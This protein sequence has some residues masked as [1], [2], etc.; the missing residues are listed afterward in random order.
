MRQ[1]FSVTG[2]T[3]T[4]CSSH[5]EKAVS[6]LNGVLSVNVNLLQNSMTVE[7]DENIL[8][9]GDIAN[10][11]KA[12]GYSA[13]AD[14][15]KNSGSTGSVPGNGEI[16][17]LSRQ[18]TWSLIFLIPLF[19]I[20]MGH[21]M[22]APLPAF[23]VGENN[24]L[25]FA[26]VQFCLTLPILYF[27]RNYFSDGFSALF[28]RSPNMNSLVA[29]GS[30]AAVIYSIYSLFAAAYAAGQNDIH[31]VHNHV[32]NLYFESAGMILTLITLGKF[33]ESR[34]KKSTTEAI[35]RLMNLA[36]KTA[37]VI[38]NGREF[39]I[40]AEDLITGD[41]VVIKPGASIP[42]DG[43]VTEGSSSID[44]SA[45]T[46]ESIPVEKEP[47]SHLFA[48]TINNTG[49]F[50]MKV[51]QVGKDTTLS[52]IIALVEEA[53]N[54]K[55]PIS[56]LADK[57]SGI[58]VPVV[59]TIALL[60]AVIWY[61]IG[62]PFTFILRTAISV[63]VISCPCALG[64]A[65]PTAIMVA[66]GKGAEN[67]ILIRSAEA[68]ENLHSVNTAVFDKTGTLTEGK[69]Y[70]TD[71]LPFGISEKKLV[72][73]AVSIEQH[74][75]HPFA[76]AITEYAEQQG[77]APKKVN[78]FIS[79]SG[80]GVKASID[81]KEIIGGNLKM[82]FDN[83]INFNFDIEKYLK[84]GKTPLY[85]AADKNIIGIIFAADKIKPSAAAAVSSM[86]RLGV[87]CVMLTGD[88]K[89]VADSVKNKLKIKTVIAEVLPQD[90]EAEIRRLQESG[91][92][93][94]MIGDGINDAPAMTRADV[95]IAIGAGSDIAIESADIVLIKNDPRDAAA[96]IELSR[97][98]IKN[99]RENLFWAFF[100][101]VLGIPVAAGLFYPIFRLELNPM[102]AA[103]AMSLS[104][105]FVVLNALRLKFFKPGKNI[106]YN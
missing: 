60:S 24:L 102:I 27:N 7:Y 36:P 90:K 28:K 83:N 88:H 70:V 62:M 97:A 82:L 23:L 81:G 21:M 41:T 13:S 77:I 43:I 14:S 85:F 22:G 34:A 53:G 100:Y 57:I 91:R 5:I 8:N 87:D 58:F 29:L 66:T 101:N 74:S 48:A 49:S 64:L 79:V 18:F 30:A 17:P 106:L 75:E 40:P 47:G 76:A 42:A 9:D 95:G 96:A 15:G 19:Y 20:S 86:T 92:K 98:T 72:E 69:P 54:S 93:A 32:M 38:R 78:D 11:V 3:C 99:I 68:L 71:I 16:N 39:T 31:A 84:E 44:E 105:V 73:T 33:L 1:K 51:T 10:A 37:V 80:R 45:L 59:I 104:S 67:G 12:S 6:K 2:M 4:S 94:V 55:A 52:Q 50:K 56:R 46:G 61:F 26:L 25:V 63:L 103:A 35:S 89:R 65:T